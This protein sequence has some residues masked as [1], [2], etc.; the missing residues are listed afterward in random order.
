MSFVTAVV[1]EAPN[2]LVEIPMH[3]IVYGLI[4]LT[5]FAVLGFV[6]WSY[7]SVAHRHAPA[8]S[9][10]APHPGHDVTATKNEH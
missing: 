7:R 9:A 1:T 5:T 8:A 2:V 3:P 4:S 10:H 6:L